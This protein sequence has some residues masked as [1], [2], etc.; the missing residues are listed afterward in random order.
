MAEIYDEPF[1]DSSNI[2]TYLISKEAV[3]THRVILT[4]DGGDELM[5]GYGFW[6]KNLERLELFK[7][8][9]NPVFNSV[10]FGKVLQKFKF[11][12]LSAYQQKNKLIKD[13]GIDIRKIHENQN[14]YFSEEELSKLGLTI[15]SS[16]KEYSFRFENNVN[17]AMKMDIE[18]YMPGD[19]LVKTDRASM[20]NS[21]ELRAPFLDIDLANFLISLPYSLKLNNKEEKLIAKY[22]FSNLP[23]EIATRK[24]QGFGAPIH[25]WLQIK[26]VIDLKDSIL[27]NANSK[28]FSFLDFDAVQ[29]YSNQKNYKTWILLNLALWF[30]NNL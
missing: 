22:A 12:Q 18:N 17:D 25:R 24:K 11:P 23:R 15:I 21:L 6:Y 8:Y 5:G 26:E 10:F 3:K 7:T 1:A 30:E 19:I 9:N 28:I 13:F 29:K 2:P 27:S 20:A 16:E 14:C 4:G